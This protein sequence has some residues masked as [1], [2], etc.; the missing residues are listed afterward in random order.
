M[1]RYIIVESKNDKFFFEGL[2]ESI[3]PNNAVKITDVEILPLGVGLSEASLIKALT[4]IRDEVGKLTDTAQIGILLD[5]DTEKIDLK[6]GETQGGL[7]S[8]LLL[9]NNTIQKVLL[10]DLA[11]T[12]PCVD[13]SNFKS[14]IYKITDEESINF[15]VGCHFININGEGELETLQKAIATGNPYAADCMRAWKDCYLAKIKS[16]PNTDERAKFITK[17]ID[18]EGERDKVFDKIWKEFYELYDVF[19]EKEFDRWWVQFYHRHD[20]LNK[21]EKK[22]AAQNTA[23]EML[24]TGKFNGELKGKPRG[25]DIYNFDS[26]LPEFQALSNF[27]RAFL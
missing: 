13:I 12:E 1:I 16:I 27:L 17:L 8:R 25:S 6:K 9:V 23:Y 5:M 4:D 26:E 22:Q 15:S 10:H 20:V 11:F 2:L 19:L 21:D 14:A 7:Q 3:A 18:K 24:F